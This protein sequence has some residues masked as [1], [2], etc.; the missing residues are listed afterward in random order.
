MFLLRARSTVCSIVL[1][2]SMAPARTARCTSLMLAEDSW[3]ETS[4]RRTNEYLSREISHAFT[5][6]S[7]LISSIVATTSAK[8]ATVLTRFSR[9]RTSTAA[10][11]AA[12]AA[13]FVRSKVTIA[14]AKPITLA[15]SP[16]CFRKKP[17][18]S[19]D[20]IQYTVAAIVPEAKSTDRV[21]MIQ[22]VPSKTSGRSVC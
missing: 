7:L 3:T 11:F 2:C 21:R 12:S 9:L 6:C 15:T 1:N 10:R 17:R 20:V 16:Q 18:N 13:L 14:N 22:Q 4:Y 8:S 5:R 19:S